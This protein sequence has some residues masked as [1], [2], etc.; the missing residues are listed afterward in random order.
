MVRFIVLLSFFIV[1]C[2]VSVF[3]FFRFVPCLFVAGKE[4]CMIS[5]WFHS[6]LFLIVSFRVYFVRYHLLFLFILYHIIFSC[7]WLFVFC[8]FG[9]FCFL[10]MID[11]FPWVFNCLFC[12]YNLLSSHFVFTYTLFSQRQLCFLIVVFHFGSCSFSIAS[13]R[14]LSFRFSLQLLRRPQHTT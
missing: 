5:F 4:A 13:F 2:A 10:F 9:W 1:G 11:S 14:C 8:N 7:L 12:F 3:C 6:A